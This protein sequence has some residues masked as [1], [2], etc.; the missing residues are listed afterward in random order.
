M[1]VVATPT[2]TG[3]VYTHAHARTGTGRGGF[4]KIVPIGIPTY[5]GMKTGFHANVSPENQFPCRRQA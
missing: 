4:L 1:L 5:A 2:Q 3:Y